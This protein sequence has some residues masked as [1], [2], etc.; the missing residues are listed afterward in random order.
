MA[1]TFSL[2]SFRRSLRESERESKLVRQKAKA[3]ENDVA[4]GTER[5]KVDRDLT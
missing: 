3:L 5:K 4:Q 2:K 1:K